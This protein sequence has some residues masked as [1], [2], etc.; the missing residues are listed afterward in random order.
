MRDEPMEADAHDPGGP[1]YWQRQQELDQEGYARFR[2]AEV[3][4]IVAVLSHSPK[5]G[6]AVERV[7][8]IAAGL[9]EPEPVNE[10]QQEIPFAA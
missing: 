8:L 10:N 2:I 4:G 7:L 1:D 3:A 6:E 5:N 9:K